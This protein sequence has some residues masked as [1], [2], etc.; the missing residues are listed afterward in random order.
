MRLLVPCERERKIEREREREK[1]TE[2]YIYIYVCIYIY[3]HVCI[4]REREGG[5]ITERERAKQGVASTLALLVP[6][7]LRAGPNRLFQTP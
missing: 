6:P 5:R 7:A 4:E 2:G 3:M 1:E